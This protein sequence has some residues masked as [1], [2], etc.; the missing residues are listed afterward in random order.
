MPKG[1]FVETEGF[2]WGGG[3]ETSVKGVNGHAALISLV[4]RKCNFYH[5]RQVY[6]YC[7]EAN[8]S[9]ICCNLNSRTRL[10][11]GNDDCC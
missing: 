1:I 4:F 6:R 2:V 11:A 5:Y 9:E 10:Q 7:L 3:V 8:I